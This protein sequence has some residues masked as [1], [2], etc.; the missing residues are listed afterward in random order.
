MIT[1]GTCLN[2]RRKIKTMQMRSFIFINL[3][4]LYPFPPKIDQTNETKF[5][6]LLIL[7]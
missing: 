6:K 1:R 5:G 2:G 3:F 4:S 7:T